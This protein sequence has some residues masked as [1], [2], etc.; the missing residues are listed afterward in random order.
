ML[1][2]GGPGGRQMG[3]R[4]QIQKLIDKKAI[5]INDLQHRLI[6]AKAFVHGLQES[7]RLAPKSGDE[8]GGESKSGT[9]PREG[10]F[11]AQAREYVKLIGKPVHISEIL[12]GLGR[13]NTARN[14]A[15]G[16]GSISSYARRGEIFVRTKAN[17][18]GLIG[19]EPK[20]A[21]GPPANFGVESDSEE[22]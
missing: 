22:G 15:S 8:D 6:E 11:V 10:S 17:T 21:A 19:M 18:F 2:S 9:E 13:E 16:S 20:K 5:E 1:L 4:E 7:L 3:Y 12:K 14:R